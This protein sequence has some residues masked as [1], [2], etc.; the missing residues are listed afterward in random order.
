MMVL[1]TLNL[2]FPNVYW[3]VRKTTDDSQC[4]SLE[5]SQKSFFKQPSNQTRDCSPGASV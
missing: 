2:P 3:E 5:E 1:F 4:V